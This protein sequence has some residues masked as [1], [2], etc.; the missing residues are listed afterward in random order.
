MSELPRRFDDAE[1]LVDE[2]LQRLG[3]SLV[4]GLPLGLGKANHLINALFQRAQANPKISL[5]ICTALTLEKPSAK[6]DLEQRFI[7]PLSARLFDDYPVLEYAKAMRSGA[8]PS[9]I[10][11]REFFM[12]PGGWLGVPLAQ[13]EYTSLNYTHALDT[14]L[15]WK[16]NLVLQLVAPGEQSADGQPTRYSLS[17]NP[18]ISADLLERRRLGELPLLSVGQVNHA[19]PFM[20]GAADRPASDFDCILQ[21]EQYEFPLFT[22]PHS[23]AATKHHAIGLRVASLIAD[24]GTLQ[25]GIGSIGDA[26]AH[27]LRL[28]QQQPQRFHALLRT[29]ETPDTLPSRHCEP[30][31][32]GLYGVTEML[33]E[34]F[35]ALIE[36][37]VI[38]REVDGKLIHAGFFIG[39]PVLYE[40]LERLPES[41]RNKIAMMPVSYTNSLYGDEQAKRAARPKARFINSAVMVTLTG[42]VVSDG[43]ADA[44][45]ISGVGGQYNFV[46]QA[47]A[48]PDARAIITLPATRIHKGKISSNICWQYPH[49][50]IPRHLRDMVVTEY[51]VAD[52]R[53]K[54][55]AEV[56]DAMLSV[57]DAHFQ[58]ELMAQAKKAGK[59]PADYQLPVEYSRN[60]PEQLESSLAAVQQ[61]GELPAFPL[62]S[63][64][65]AEEEDLAQALSVLKVQIG[66]K[67]ALFSL[68]WL[69]VRVSASG[70]QRA[71]LHRMGL[72]EAGGVRERV[73]RALLLATL[74]C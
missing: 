19:L 58:Q 26:I 43:L 15:R 52:L 6:S 51:G 59:L 1:A 64:M 47:F 50:T 9:N 42:S 57:S 66:S 61:Q 73:Y 54:S 56:I 14:L 55:D 74:P 4:V 5:T 53:D 62:G 30:F 16:V 17:C 32:Q 10:T 24:G 22:P 27:A 18:D 8:L 33:V 25:I 70:R 68:F 7:G 49:T 40:I 65:S 72:A 34:G 39:S 44:Q 21:S 45:V 38:K 35:L 60:T 13:Q 67:R 36:A 48:L 12:Q 37:G 11:V 46:A 29:L 23:P 28:R 69:G 71:A 3:N 31:E 63:G 20:G 41:T 2:I